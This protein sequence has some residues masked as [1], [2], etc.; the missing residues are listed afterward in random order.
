MIPAPTIV[1]MKLKDALETELSPPLSILFASSFPAEFSDDEFK[2]ESSSWARLS[3]IAVS[4]CCTAPLLLSR[5]A[6][7]AQ[8]LKKL[9][10][11]TGGG[12]GG[13]C[14]KNTTCSSTHFECT[15][16]RACLARTWWRGRGG[17]GEKTYGRI[18]KET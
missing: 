12:G 13:G 1:L 4:S 17:G 14:L 9:K 10:C 3:D 7:R 2:G 11:K 18:K 15:T 8:E 6:M 5:D 16:W